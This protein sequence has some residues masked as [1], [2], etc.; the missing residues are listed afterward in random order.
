MYSFMDINQLLGV[1]NMFLTKSSSNQFLNVLCL[2]IQDVNHK[3][4]NLLVNGEKNCPLHFSVR[5]LEAIAKQ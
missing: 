5:T 3:K 1:I 4:Y 2:Q